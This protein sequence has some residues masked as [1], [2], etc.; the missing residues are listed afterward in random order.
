MLLPFFTAPRNIA[1][2]KIRTQLDAGLEA[3]GAA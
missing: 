1:H 2:G 3:L